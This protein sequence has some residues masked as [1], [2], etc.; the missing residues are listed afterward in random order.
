MGKGSI[1]KNDG[2]RVLAQHYADYLTEFDFEVERV[3]VDTSYGK[4]H[5][6]V[7]GPPEAKP[8]FLFQGGNCINPM[9]FSW[10]L[11]LVE[12]YRIYAPDTIGH[13]GFSDENRI[14]AKDD[15]FAQWT[16]EL[17]DYFQIER[18]AFVGPSYGAGII[19]RLA[20]YMPDKITCAVL[21]APAGIQ[22][23]SKLT[24]I[25]KILLPLVFYHGTSS[26]KYLDQIADHMS[27]SSMKERDK[28]IIGDVFKYVKL[29]QDMPKLT[30]KAE[31]DNYHSP[32][33]I[34]AGKKDLFFPE[35]RIIKAARN[36]FP[37]LTDFKSYEMGHFPAN[38]H[39]RKINH[40][41]EEFLKEYY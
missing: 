37:N 18:C 41:I 4:T 15:S 3:Y 32:T 21:V 27:D 40:D 39:L 36:I 6:L 5:L 34:I 28:T 38:D 24:M 12:N 25:K 10:F 33:L 29:E 23:G 7:A 2:K 35:E 16:S 19:L 20:T 26:P 22:L 9:T 8:I 1:Y 11:P 31:L 13:P 14:S 17:L 30:T